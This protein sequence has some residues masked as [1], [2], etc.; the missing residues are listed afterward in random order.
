MT[1]TPSAIW[2]VDTEKEHLAVKEA[3]NLE[4]PV[5][6][7][8]DTNANPDEVTYPIPGNDDAIRSVAVLTR[9]I[10]NPVADDLMIRNQGKNDDTIAEEPMTEKERNLP[11]K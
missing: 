1:R 4:I 7:I 2:V 10:A 3:N 11:T 8:L 9:V 5:V 6:A